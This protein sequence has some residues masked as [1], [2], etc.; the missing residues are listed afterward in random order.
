MTHTPV[1]PREVPPVHVSER[2]KA[3]IGDLARPFAI[4]ATSFS[5]AWATI[6]ISSKVENGNDGAIFAG[7]YF[8][9][10]ATLYGAKAVEAINTARTRRDVDVAAVNAGNTTP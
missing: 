8:L 5:A 9:G 4:I 7:A 2:V 1:T 10:V 3:F 6:V